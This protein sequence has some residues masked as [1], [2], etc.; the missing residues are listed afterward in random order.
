ME[1]RSEYPRPRFQRPD[2]I[3]LNGEWEFGAGERPAFDRHINVPFCPES[4][5]SGIA[6]L[7]GD[8]VWYR[9][10]FDAPAGDCVLLHFCPA[11]YPATVWVNDV[12]AARHGGRDTPVSVAI[13]KRLRARDNAL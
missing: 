2:W 5:L 13:T 10:P 7:P 3:N 8:A 11:H 4:K 6:A 9:R 1:P 12:E